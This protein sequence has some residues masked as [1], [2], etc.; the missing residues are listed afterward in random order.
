MNLITVD[1]PCTLEAELS[2]TTTESD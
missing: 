1:R 2:A